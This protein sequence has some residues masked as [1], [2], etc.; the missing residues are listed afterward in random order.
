MIFK[1]DMNSRHCKAVVNI[2]RDI[3]SKIR[4]SKYQKDMNNNKTIHYKEYTALQD[5]SIKYIIPYIN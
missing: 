3:S 2:H 4:Y 5:I 1:D